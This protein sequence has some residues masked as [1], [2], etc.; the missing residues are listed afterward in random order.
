VLSP[1]TQQRTSTGYPAVA[2]SSRRR[3]PHSVLWSLGTAI[4]HAENQYQAASEAGL[5]GVAAAWE[6]LRWDNLSRF[7]P[8]GGDE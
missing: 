5:D 2:P 1:V 6:R 4:D 8:A 7:V 3:R